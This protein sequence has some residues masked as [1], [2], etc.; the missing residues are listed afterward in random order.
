[1][2]LLVSYKINQVLACTVGTNKQRHTDAQKA[3]ASALKR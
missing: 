1:M 2:V 3:R